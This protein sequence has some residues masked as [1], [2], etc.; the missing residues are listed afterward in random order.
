MFGVAVAAFIQYKTC[1]HCNLLF[2]ADWLSTLG[3][4]LKFGMDGISLLMVMLTTFLVPVIILSSFNH[5]YS[6]PS[7]FY[8]LIFLMEMA[9]IGVFTSFDGLIFYIFWELAL[10]P[11]WFIC[12]VWGGKDRIRITFK[13]FIYTFVGSL[14]MLVA[15][16]Y[17]YFL[18]P[19]P[20]S[21]DF[22]WLYAAT[23]TPVEQT[24]IFAAF[25][26]AF[27]IKIPV[28]PLHTW[29]PDTYTTAPGTGSMLLAGIMLKMGI[30]GMIRWMIPVCHIAVKQYAPVAI[31]LAITGIV[32]A[33]V[34]AIRQNDMKRLVAYSSIAHVGLI[35]A[36]VFTLTLHSL[37]GAVIQMVSHGINIVGLFV[38]IDAIEKRTNTRNI[39][40]LGGIALKAPR[41][42]IVFMIILLG[43]IALP[44]TNGFIGEFLL[45]LGLFEYSVVF[46]AIA[47][48]TIIFS[49]VYMLWMYQ[50]TMLGRTNAITEQISDLTRIE[51][52]ALIPVVIMIFWIGLFPG[53]FL[54]VT[55]PDV[56]QIIHFTK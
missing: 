15:L 29:Q 43:S 39:S 55:L 17:L 2:T 48:L 25:F 28:F 21:F 18:T 10:I 44:L 16:I 50:R 30:Y 26:L 24:W 27:A 33:S 42:A 13:F 45:L 47:G 7:A 3:V 38:V 31:I 54:D 4:S 5:S 14:F 52:A 37:E 51:M 53:M 23:L 46:A 40:D 36:G 9:L 35:A 8:S 56:L 11:A 1:S 22:Q 12:A 32:Y 34:I 19:L 20:H 6:R 49:A 41:L